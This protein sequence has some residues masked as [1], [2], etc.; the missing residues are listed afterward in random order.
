M[1]KNS[2][3]MKM[4]TFIILAFSLAFV[5]SFTNNTIPPK[6]K[7]FVVAKVGS[8]Q[9]AKGTK[10]KLLQ[11]FRAEY[12]KNAQ[13]RD[14]TLIKMDDGDIWLAFLGGGDGTPTVSMELKVV[15]GTRVIDLGGPLQIN[16]CLTTD[17]CT[18][19]TTESACSKKNGGQESCGTG[20]CIS[21]TTDDVISSA[22]ASVLMN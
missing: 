13:V 8:K 2:K 20:S 17:D 18:C 14:I 5:F 12:S 10:A 19:C 22:M 4:M 21:K 11:A 9:I 16:N 7:H 3:T 15:N 6:D 1:K